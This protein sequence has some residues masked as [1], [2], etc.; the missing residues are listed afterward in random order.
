MPRDRADTGRHDRSIAELAFL[1]NDSPDMTASK[2]V[3]VQLSR[4]K[5]WRMPPNTVKVDRTTPFG[6]PFPIDPFP[7]D[8]DRHTSVEAF[9]TWI[10]STD[11]GHAIAERAKAQLRGKNLACWCPLDGPCHADVLIDVANA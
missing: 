2:P 7:I 9:R 8:V 10:S 11:E 3:R 5:G 4:G 1:P 6:N